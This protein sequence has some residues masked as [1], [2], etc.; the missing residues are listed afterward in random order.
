LIDMIP[1][2]AAPRVERKQKEGPALE[3]DY[4]SHATVRAGSPRCIAR[5]RGKIGRWN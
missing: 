2:R 3:P 1:G 4:L 5:V